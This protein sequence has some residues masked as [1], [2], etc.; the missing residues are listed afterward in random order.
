MKATREVEVDAL[1]GSL[2]SGA[3]FVQTSPLKQN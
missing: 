1:V 3:A 2:F